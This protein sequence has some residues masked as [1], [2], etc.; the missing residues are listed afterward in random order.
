[1][2]IATAKRAPT[3]GLGVLEK[4]QENYAAAQASLLQALEIFAEFSDQYSTQVVLNNLTRRLPNYSRRQPTHRSRPVPKR[5]RRRSHTA[6][7]HAEQQQFCLISTRY[8]RES[9][10]R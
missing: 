3:N 8:S 4:S 6:I 9:F 7:R 1:M 5:N 10:S 2:A